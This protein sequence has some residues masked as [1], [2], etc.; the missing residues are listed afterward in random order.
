MNWELPEEGPITKDNSSPGTTQSPEKDTPEEVGAKA[1]WGQRHGHLGIMWTEFSGL[2]GLLL[3]QVQAECYGLN[4]ILPKKMCW[5]PNQAV[6]Q[7]VALFGKRI[8][9]DAI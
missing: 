6:P 7:N 3:L 1:L 2:W 4:C 9:A 5:S 8:I